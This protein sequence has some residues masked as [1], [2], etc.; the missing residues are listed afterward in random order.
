[1]V[2]LPGQERTDARGGEPSS[3][4][5]SKLF[6]F[7]TAVALFLAV[8]CACVPTA[9]ADS[10]GATG[11]AGLMEHLVPSI[12]IIANRSNAPSTYALVLASQWLMALVYAYALLVRSFPFSRTMRAMAAE[13]FAEGKLRQPNRVGLAVLLVFALLGLLSSLGVISW[14]SIYNG[15]YVLSRSS[16]LGESFFSSRTLL[17]GYAWLTCINIVLINW[18]LLIVAANFGWMFGA[19]SA[20]ATL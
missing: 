7:S 10:S 18:F 6:G 16:P 15:G 19:R 12:G 4:R 13:K 9:W 3:A 2:A 5:G 20:R 17:V 8:S 1:M 11:F 14:P